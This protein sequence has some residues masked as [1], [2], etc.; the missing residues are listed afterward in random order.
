MFCENSSF[1]DVLGSGYASGPTL[2]QVIAG[3]P[4][5][6]VLKNLSPRI[7][8]HLDTFQNYYVFLKVENP[9]LLVL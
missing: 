6:I 7:S 5:F 2:L 1:L 9:Y 8:V 4:H 3:D